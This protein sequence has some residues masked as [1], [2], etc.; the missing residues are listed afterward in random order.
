MT[1]EEPEV[2]LPELIEDVP[3]EDDLRDMIT[4]SASGVVERM[5]ME[6]RKGRAAVRTMQLLNT[7][8]LGVMDTL[9]ELEAEPVAPDRRGGRVGRQAIRAAMGREPEEGWQPGFN[10]H[11]PPNVGANVGANSVVGGG[12]GDYFETLTGMLGNLASETKEN[13]RVKKI[14]NLLHAIETA[15]RIEKADVVEKLEAELNA[16]MDRT[17]VPNDGH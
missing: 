1:I 12:L 9:R 13:D 16:V 10:I 8:T 6:L 2:I 4:M 17:E 15:K 14:E 5:A 3:F 11:V 7:Y